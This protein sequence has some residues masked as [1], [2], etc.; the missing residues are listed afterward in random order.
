MC[1]AVEGRGAESW[2]ILELDKP[3]GGETRPGDQ[4]AMVGVCAWVWMSNQCAGL[5]HRPLHSSSVQENS[6]YG[7]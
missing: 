6:D 4:R 3:C 5:G 1:N 7:Y 2:D